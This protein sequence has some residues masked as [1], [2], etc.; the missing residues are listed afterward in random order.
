VSKID[1]SKDQAR[2]FLINYQGLNNSCSLKSEKGIF[3][4]FKRV[5][6]IKYDP[7]NVVGRNADLVLQSQI[8][9]YSPDILEK[10]LNTDRSLIDGWDKMMSIYR[11]VD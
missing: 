2:N 10:L 9:G 11:Q 5:G 4:Y 8:P 3:E 7:L 6:C 1:I